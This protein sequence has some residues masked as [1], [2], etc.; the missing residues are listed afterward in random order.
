MD[1]TFHGADTELLAWL[2]RTGVT[3]QLHEHAAAYT[4]QGA[5]FAE[6]VDPHRFAKVVGVETDTHSRML[7]VLRASDHV[8]LHKARVILGARKV[9]LLSEPELAEV[10]P[11]SEMGALPAVGMLYGLPVIADEAIKGLPD[12]T[13]NAGSHR[14]SVHV[15]RA[16][17]ERA[18]GV[19]YADLAQDEDDRPNWAR[20]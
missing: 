1:A 4:A 7:F 11:T 20:S 5:A 15:D 6:G 17:W 2:A 12:L 16:A 13:F 14:V 18:A 8:D 19:L 9:R 3:H 10:A